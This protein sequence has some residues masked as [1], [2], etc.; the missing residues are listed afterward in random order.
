LSALNKGFGHFA[1]I[2]CHCR[3]QKFIVRPARATQ[4]QAPKSQDAFEVGEQHLNLLRSRRDWRFSQTYPRLVKAA[5]KNQLKCSAF[6]LPWAERKG[7]TANLRAHEK[8]RG[9][10]RKHG[11]LYSNGKPAFQNTILKY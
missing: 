11:Y 8:S 5:P 3:K 4:S 1:Q 7:T 2:L 9:L 10:S 6:T